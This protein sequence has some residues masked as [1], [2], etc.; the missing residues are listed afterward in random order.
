MRIPDCES[1]GL[2]VFYR[3]FYAV[4]RNFAVRSERRKFNRSVRIRFDNVIAYV[5]FGS[6]K[7][8][9]VAEDTRKTH[10]VLVF[11][12]R[13][14]AVFKHENVDFV[15]SVHAK[16]G[17][18]ELGNAVR[19]LRVSDESAVYVQ[20]ETRIHTLEVKVLPLAVLFQIERPRIMPARVV[21]WYVRRI[22]R[23]G[24]PEVNVRELIVAVNLHAGRNGDFRD[25]FVFEKVVRNVVKR[26]VRRYPP[27]AAEIG[28]PSGLFAIRKNVLTRSERNVIR[29]G[30]E[31]P[32]AT[33]LLKE[34]FHIQLHNLRFSAK[35][36]TKKPCLL[37][38][39][40][41]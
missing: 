18:I 22:E 13:A 25:A 1:R 19:N 27:L 15:L 12:V 21:V 6:R 9:D 26:F 31:N 16:V 20:I 32:H 2:S 4:K 5:L 39:T 23:Y 14:F 30:V 11:E 35:T 41:F 8:V 34:F 10:F 7:K 17:N 37:H 38:Y 24:V 33:R 3:F 29:S 28:E 36:Q 40:R